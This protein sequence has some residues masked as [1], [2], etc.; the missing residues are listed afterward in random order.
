MSQF[1]LEL[2]KIYFL[3]LA[4]IMFGWI[5]RS[6]IDLEKDKYLKNKDG[7]DGEMSFLFIMCLTWPVGLFLIYLQL[8]LRAILNIFITAAKWLTKK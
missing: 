6:V 3:V 7:S 1:Y 4:G 8:S 2:L 5:N